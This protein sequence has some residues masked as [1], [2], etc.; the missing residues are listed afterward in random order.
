MN[1][2]PLRPQRSAEEQFSAK[3]FQPTRPPRGTMRCGRKKLAD[4]APREPFTL[5][6]R[7]TRDAGRLRAKLNFPTT[8][9]AASIPSPCLA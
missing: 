1:S 9:W 5:R 3:L 6:E 7:S 2:S 4:A 8:A